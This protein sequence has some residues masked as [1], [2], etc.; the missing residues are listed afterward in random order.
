M[1]SVQEAM[2][3]QISPT[4][5][6]SKTQKELDKID[7]VITCESCHVKKRHYMYCVKK[8][9]NSDCTFH[10]P[11]WLPSEVFDDLNFLPDPMLASFYHHYNPCAEV[12]KSI[13]NEMARP[14]RPEGT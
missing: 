11:L 2:Q 6:V 4:L 8:C 10:K 13:T 5:T 3:V 9:S 7:N 12:Y 1:E 14:S